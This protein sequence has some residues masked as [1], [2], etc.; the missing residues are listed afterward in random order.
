MAFLSA[1]DNL[2]I[3]QLT[4]HPV[5]DGNADAGYGPENPI[6]VFDVADDP[7]LWTGPEDLSG[8]LR[9]GWINNSLYLFIDVTDDV[10]DTDDLGAPYNNDGVEI[11]FDGDNS[12][13]AS[14]ADVINDVQMRI[15][16]DDPGPNIDDWGYFAQPGDWWDNSTSHFAISEKFDG[17]Y[18]VEISLEIEALR[19]EG[20]EDGYFGFDAQ[21]NDADGINRE[22]MLRWHSDNNDTWH[23]AH[24]LGN[25]TLTDY[26]PQ[27]PD[28]D[29]VIG[30]PNLVIYT[31]T[32]D[33][34]EVFQNTTKS[35][36]L[37]VYNRG[38]EDLLIFSIVP[39]NEDYSI[40]PDYASMDSLESEIFSV[41][42]TPS[43]IG[44]NTTTLTFENNDP[45]S[46][47]YII[48]LTGAG[49]EPPDI[50]VSPDS[51]ESD[52]LSGQTDTQILNITNETG[53]DLTWSIAT[54]YVENSTL[55]YK[56]EIFSGKRTGHK[57][58]TEPTE[59]V[60][61]RQS[62]IFQFPLLSELIPALKNM[63]AQNRIKE[64]D[65]PV[66]GSD[67][68]IQAN[69]LEDIVTSLNENFPDIYNSIPNRYNFTDGVTG[70]YIANGG[71]NM[72]DYGNLLST[73]LS[74]YNYIYYSNNTITSSSYFGSGGRYFTKKDSGLF[75]LV[76]DINNVNYFEIEGNLGAWGMGNVDGSILQS[77]INGITY[78][79]FVKRV[80]NATTPSVNHLIIVQENS[81]VN[82]Q[83]STYT[84][85]DYHQVYN[86][87]ASTRIY[88]L[89][90]AGV[91]GF[92]IDDDAT[93][94][95]MDIFISSLGIV[96]PWLSLNPSSGI[97]QAGNTTPVEVTFDATG[98]YGGNYD[99]D[100]TITSND[101][102]E[103]LIHVPAILQVTGVP[104]ISV[105]TDTLDFNEVF[106][107][108]SLSL[109]LLV[110]NNGSDDLIISTADI[111]P[112]EYTVLP[113][114]LE[115][116]PGRRAVITVTFSPQV[117]GDY[118]GT[119]TL[120]SN[121]PDEETYEIILSG[122]GVEPPII[123]VSP[124]SLNEALLS[125]ETS[126]QLLT[127]SNEGEGTLYYTFPGFAAVDLLNK[128]PD[129]KKNRSAMDI[130]RTEYSKDE[131][132]TRRGHPVVLGAG[133]PDTFGY[134]WIDSDEPGGP[135]FQWE[136]ISST[137]TLI[138]GLSDDNYAGPFPIG[139]Q[140][141]F[142]E[143]QYSQFYVQSNGLIN[144]DNTY[145]SLS[146]QPIPTQDS[147]NNFIA[148]CWDDLYCW[149][150][151]YVY[152]QDFGNRLIIQFVDYGEC[153]DDN[154][155]INAEIILYYT[156]NITIRYLNYYGDFYLNGSTIGIENNNGTDGLQV[157]FNTNY[158]HE[159]LALDFLLVPMWLS[160]NPSSGEVSSGSSQDIDISFDA[161]GMYGGDYYENLI[162][163]SNDPLT[164]EVD[165][166]V[167]LN[168]TGV[169][170]IDI[171]L[172]EFDE[173]SMKYWNTSDATTVH[174]F[175]VS[176]ESVDDGILTVTIYGE[177][178]NEWQYADV[179]IES[180]LI[181]RI[182]PTGTQATEHFIIPQVSLN[183]YIENGSIEVR[184]DNSMDVYPSYD[185]YHSVRL[186]YYG[187]DDTLDFKGVFLNHLDSSEIVIK[188]T[189]TET[190][191]I[192]SVTV[193]SAAFTVAPSSMNLEPG[194]KNVV[195]VT[196]LPTAERKYTAQISIASNDDDE[197]LT[198][199]PVIGEGLEPPIIS[200]TPDSLSE[201]SSTGEISTQKLTISN[202]DGGSDLSWEI[203][204]EYTDLDTVT[205][206]KQDYV[207]WTNPT[208]QDRITDNV[209][210]T[211]ASNQGI[212][213][214]ATESGYDY[215]ISPEGTEWAYGLTK[216]LEPEDYQVWREAVYANPPGMVDQPISLH[217]IEDDRYLDILFHSWTA[218]N[219]GGGF[220]YT[221][222]G[223]PDWLSVSPESGLTPPDSAVDISVTF[224]ASELE[225]REY[226]ASIIVT[227][228][229]P[230]NPEIIIPVSLK[231]GV[232]GIEDPYAGKIP[233]TYVLF[234][235]YPNPFNPITYIRY[236]LPK[237]GRVEIILY[238]ILGQ[239]IAKLVDEDKK[240]G[241]HLIN[242]N[243][244][245]FA[246]GMYI[247]RMKSGNF[248]K[249]MKMLL[250]K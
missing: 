45:D 111:T 235:N 49:I 129:I 19:L 104:D 144:F 92:Y 195:N 196:F 243:A 152:Y 156:G 151:S 14:S 134:R 154:G 166:P 63:P 199:I 62:D 15:E 94:N 204:I 112:E 25:A 87:S 77:T 197:E 21:I 233:K 6:E 56:S 74:N 39:G 221:R 84:Y 5:I 208:N 219:S 35:L 9:C 173:T 172:Y 128:T 73:S 50:A 224:D 174:N 158:I 223:R 105:N 86:L 89:L 71:N 121:D 28:S 51:L 183:N 126:S 12:K 78:Y 167:H 192:S 131:V 247:Y 36:P 249:V 17:G 18:Y 44:I 108:T 189:G 59:P 48:T 155:R 133:G 187:P 150:D 130:P 245:R 169:P 180:D 8:N 236:G 32:L 250:I 198:I 244:N 229:D 215:S 26:N 75:V 171:S 68:S 34:E 42:F 1:A 41:S 40:I 220:S 66:N 135:V 119:L 240:A 30:E 3:Y 136:D 98:L 232:V 23:W 228:N 132:D 214:A 211:R 206:T 80:Y 20:D 127:I 79:G 100:L 147:Y 22:T 46:S 246:S 72:Y 123:A 137:G 33:F 31:D 29:I 138:S 209:W 227:N 141:P 163:E 114:L 146:N 52:L 95:I 226:H 101:P 38:T 143:N 242:F 157:A 113:D 124:D 58:K 222:V 97:I 177:Y 142:Y 200:V 107:G 203:K 145:I 210:I 148:W 149:Y 109:E 24:L 47:N 2:Q 27:P 83:F 60:K 194:E 182:N 231:V 188:N 37:T 164:P 53:A 153:C 85:D 70:Y 248:T 170:E 67:Y 54:N 176:F 81:A 239:R 125:G 118:P 178:Y 117:S 90:Y 11:F 139:F 175:D 185:S 91:N 7:S 116:R 161:T 10:Y 140:F 238:N 13:I 64:P 193:D 186:H 43:L 218:G 201:S 237:A 230:L 212:F 217:L 225:N 160:V 213:N 65:D 99:A 115:I 4:E 103:S 110:S 184:V 69:T 122:Q 234:Q 241:Y 216:D 205:F 57:D 120:T 181:G 159:N 202:P 55:L 93:L 82:H 191:E 190:L 96:P 61:P 165:I 168:V 102:D 179:F 162:I 106:L 88:Y 207:D 16:R 76:A